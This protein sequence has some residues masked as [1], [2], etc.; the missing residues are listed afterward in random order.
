LWQ[1]EGGVS[2]PSLTEL[3]EQADRDEPPSAL[4]GPVR[5]RRQARELGLVLASQ[6]IE[7]APVFS[8]DGWALRVPRAEAARAERAIDLYLEE[9]KNWPPEDRP[10]VP[11]HRRSFAVAIAFAL[12]G[13]F[14]SVV[15]GPSRLGSHWFVQGRA[16]A[17]LLFSE[18]WRMVTA[19]TLH[20]D[21]QH[22]LGNVLSGAIFGSAVSRRLGPGGALC[23]IVSAGAVGNALNALVHLKHG[24]VSIGASTAV[25]AAI[26]MLAGIQAMRVVGRR[27]EPS[28][29]KLRALDVLAPIAGGLALLG[30]LGSGN[31]HTDLGAHG[32]GFLAGLVLGGVVAWTRR[33]RDESEP[34]SHSFQVALGSAAVLLLSGAWALAVM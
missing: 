12:L 32:F 24:H 17:V 15:T 2:V 30:S 13:L 16:D 14:F 9:N 29:K 5:D 11:R 25:F 18:P 8:L 21:S 26:G 19:L 20:G 33:G 34:P 7:H 22:V 23:A 4:L 3:R 6:G 28:R 1:N 27:R 10:D 31:G